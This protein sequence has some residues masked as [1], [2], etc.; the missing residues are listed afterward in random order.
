MLGNARLCAS[1]VGQRKIGL[2]LKMVFQV[3]NRFAMTQKRRV[4]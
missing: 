2:S 3:A 4:V 1:L